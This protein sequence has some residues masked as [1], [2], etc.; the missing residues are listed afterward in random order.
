[1]T[2]EE[3]IAAAAAATSGIE[4]V[5]FDNLDDLLGISSS[6]LT[7]EEKPQTVLS[8]AR[9]DLD[10]LDDEDSEKGLENASQEKL[11]SVV[12]DLVDNADQDDQEDQTVN[13]GG[14]P[15][16]VKDAMVEAATRMIEKGILQ[17]FDDDKLLSD[18]TVEDFE[19]LIQANIESKV[20]TTAQVA[21]VELFKTLPQDVQA[22]VKYALDGGQDTKAVFQQ[23]AK[24][25]E[26]FDLD[27]EDETDQ[28]QIIREWY[29]ALGTYDSVEEL[30]D[31]LNIIK[32]RGDLRKYAERY[33]P[34][35]DAKQAEIVEKKLKEQNLAKERKE[36]AAEQY[37]G[38]IANT[39]NAT[40]LNGLPLTEKVQNMLY[41]GLVD[42]SRYQN[43]EG[44]QT[45]A[46]GFLLEQ[47]QFGPKPNP[48]LVAEA[49]WLLAD[50]E[51]YR[52]AI[53]KTVEKSTNEKTARMLRTEQASSKQASSSSIEGERGQTQTR[54]QPIQRPNRNIFSR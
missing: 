34:K 52:T 12:S 53:K 17:P 40:H 39:L 45:N 48:S 28:E 50:P 33:K 13:K 10:F 20:T 21:P 5:D 37:R 46:L 7:P 6:V 47:H 3:K 14:R 9:V 42:A 23:L 2:E 35:L 8:S 43:A 38:T 4:E 15:K 24:V 22:V 16:L 44:R 32:D 11:E 26:T 30:E 18:Y 25:N 51:D 49:L 19:E 1:M 31:E 29:N 54:K 27:V 41:Y 36:K